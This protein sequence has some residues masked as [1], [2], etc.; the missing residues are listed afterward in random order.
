VRLVGQWEDLERGLP[1]G[2]G[3]ARLRLALTNRDEASAAA[4]LLAPAQ[5]TEVESGVLAF[6]SA[7]DGSAP[8][9]D[10]FPR[11]FLGLDRAG[12]HGVL[13]V[14]ETSEIPIVFAAAANV[15]LAA[16]WA[17]ALANVPADW[18]DV[19]GE[20]ELFSSDKVER[21][22]LL[23]T[24]LNP[25]RTGVRSVLR[26]RSAS[27]FGYGGSPGMVTRCLE[28]CDAE[29]IRGTVRILRVISDSRPVG[30]QGPIWQI[31]GR[32]V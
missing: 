32:T 16:S 27:S 13:S 22:A 18:S 28:R 15:T 26:F 25:V 23:L 19:L 2:W 6:T 8:G 29:S 3:E 1:D 5:P 14:V 17:A 10:A 20:I 30:T 11:L 4:A 21:A 7:H 9:P 12:I 31:D 24:P